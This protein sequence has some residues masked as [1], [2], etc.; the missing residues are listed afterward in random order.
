MGDG[1]QPND[2]LKKTDKNKLERERE[3]VF[4]RQTIMYFQK[5]TSKDSWAR[6]GG[7]FGQDHT[8]AMHAVQTIDNLILSD[9]KIASKI[10]NYGKQIASLMDFETNIVADKIIEIIERIRNKID[11][12]EFISVETIILYN[13]L[14]E[15]TK[16]QELSKESF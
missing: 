8:T 1:S 16:Q 2:L 11:K 5:K 6:I 3:K 13:N 7:Y 4:T 9:K 15:I 12:K 14:I 10:I